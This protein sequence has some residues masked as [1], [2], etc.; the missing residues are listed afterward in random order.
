MTKISHKDS[1]LENLN[2]ELV[3]AK[4]NIELINERGLDLMAMFDQ[5]KS[6]DPKIE[7]LKQRIFGENSDQEDS[8][9]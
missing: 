2:Q 9:A 6:N 7:E 4:E 3:I 5:I 1:L 8:Y